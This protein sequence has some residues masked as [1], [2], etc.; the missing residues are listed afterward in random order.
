[1]RMIIVSAGTAL[2]LAPLGTSLP[3]ARAGRATYNYLPHPSSTES[4]RHPARLPAA[5]A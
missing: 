5:P 3:S 1:M 4:P 2:I